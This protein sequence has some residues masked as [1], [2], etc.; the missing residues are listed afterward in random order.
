MRPGAVTH[1]FDMEQRLVELA[2]TTGGAGVLNVTA[3]PNGNIAPPGYYMVFILNSAGVPSVAGFVQLSQSAADVPPTAAITS[4]A[5]DVTVNPGQAVSFAGTGNDPDG[6]ITA[7][8]W[9]FPGGSPASSSN[10]SPGNVAF[11]SPGTH[12][13]S[14]T[15]TDNAG[16]NSQP[17]TRT[18][19]V[20]GFSES[21]APAS[22]HVLPLGSTSYT[23][24]VSG[25]AG[26]TGTVGLSVSGL[27]SGASAS[28]NPGSVT[29]SGTSTMTVTT[30]LLSLPGSY[31][32][33]ITGS[34]GGLS[35][36]ATVTLR[37]G[38]F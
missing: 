25:G 33:T 20:T 37:I 34:S 15:V 7:Y 24:T 27:P 2:F 5:N 10:A 19:N 1:A 22:Q 18:I 17:A 14:L 31:P 8:S 30:S 13:A 35:R 6:S 4:P 29:G 3:P 11:T 36:T 21:A 28:F 23:V 16:L 26:F 38:L 12:V 9:L 32:L